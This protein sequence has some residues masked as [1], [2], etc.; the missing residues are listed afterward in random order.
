MSPVQEWLVPSSRARLIAEHRGHRLH[1]VMASLNVLLSAKDE[2][3]REAGADERKGV[4]IW[5]SGH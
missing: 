1:V 5:E 4:T 3:L 2:L